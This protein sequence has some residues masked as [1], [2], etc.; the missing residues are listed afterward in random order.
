MKTMIFTVLFGTLISCKTLNGCK[1]IGIISNSNT[2]I[3]EPHKSINIINIE[4]DVRLSDIWLEHYE[5]YGSYFIIKFEE[6]FD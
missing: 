4:P 5:K 3:I 6:F 2:L 1:S